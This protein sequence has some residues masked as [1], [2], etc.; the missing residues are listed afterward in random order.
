MSIYSVKELFHNLHWILFTLEVEDYNVDIWKAILSNP[1]S[2]FSLRRVIF[3][4][5]YDLITVVESQTIVDDC[6]W[7]RTVSL[8]CDQFGLHVKLLGD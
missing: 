7:V 8:E 2:N 5:H 1:P 4:P 6:V 3:I